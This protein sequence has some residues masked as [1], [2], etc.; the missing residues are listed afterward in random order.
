MLEDSPLYKLNEL[1]AAS[2]DDCDQPSEFG[3][4]DAFSHLLLINLTDVP[5]RMREGRRARLALKA[6]RIP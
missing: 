3:D 2:S 6:E 5:N 1:K 4:D